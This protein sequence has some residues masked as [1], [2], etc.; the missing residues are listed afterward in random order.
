MNEQAEADAQAWRAWHEYRNKD[1]ASPHGWLTLTSYTWSGNAAARVPGFPGEWRADEALDLGIQR[2]DAVVGAYATGSGTG[3]GT[4][5]SARAVA[6]PGDAGVDTPA[7]KD[8]ATTPTSGDTVVT[9]TPDNTAVIPAPDHTA[10]PVPAGAPAILPGDTSLTPVP[11]DAVT[12][13]D[14]PDPSAVGYPAIEVRFAPE[15]GVTQNGQPATRVRITLGEDESDFS[16]SWQGKV[17]EVGMRGGRY[18]VRVRDPEAPVR[19]EFIGVPTFPYDPTAVV[20]AAF[21]P[22][23]APRHV[24]IGTARPGLGG[25]ATLV[26]KVRFTYDGVAVTL[27]VSGDPADE[28]TA[29]FYDRTNGQETAAWRFV[30]FPGPNAVGTTPTGP[31]GAPP[32]DEVHSAGD[33]HGRAPGKACGDA[34]GKARGGVAQRVQIDFNRSLN[35]PA[36]FT[37]FGTC[38]RPVPANVVPVA[39]RAGECRYR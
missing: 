39:I 23:P 37:D 12:M 32:S 28:L 29:I 4:D 31:A 35:F 20:E 3:C 15:D 2:D 14:R 21:T 13:A 10:G 33:A 11:G 6:V 25:V 27:A 36:A 17:A 7:L 1:L 8:T 26:G 9:Q 22:Y 24:R 18:M 38:P 5:S 16:L 30:S 19:R 34:T